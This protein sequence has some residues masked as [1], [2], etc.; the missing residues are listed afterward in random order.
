VVGVVN[1][2][3]L[4]EKRAAVADSWA[5]VELS[6]SVVGGKL[7]DFRGIVVDIGVGTVGNP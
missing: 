6:S 1:W 2:E 5:R 4:V 3:A 7:D